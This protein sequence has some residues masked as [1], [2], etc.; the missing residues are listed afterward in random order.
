MRTMWS[1][2]VVLVFLMLM[3][4][5]EAQPLL[6]QWQK[7]FGGTAFE[8]GMDVQQT[9]DGGYVMA[10]FA[11]SANGDLTVNKGGR[12]FWVV[13]TDASRTIQWQISL[14][15][16]NDDAASMVKQTIDGGFIVCGTTSSADGDVTGYHGGGSD[17]WV[18]KLSST[19]TVLWKKTIGGT[20]DDIATSLDTEPT[21]TY[22]IAGLT[23]SNDGDVSGNHGNYD[24]FVVR[25][26]NNGN[27]I[28]QQCFGGTGSDADPKIKGT[29]DGGFM[30]VASTSSSD[31]DVSINHG[32]YDYWL[33]RVNNQNYITMN[34]TYGGLV[35]DQPY[36]VIQTMD[37]GY[38]I[39][40][41]ANSND[42]DV[43]GHHGNTG[44][45]DWWV[46]KLNANGSIQWQQSY[47]GSSLDVAHAILQTAD[48][49]YLVAGYVQSLDGNVTSLHG[50]Q[51]GDVDGAPDMWVIRT[52]GYGTLLWQNTFGG[53]GADY[54]NDLI[55][56]TSGIYI[57]CGVT[58]S[59]DG[60]VTGN[61][62]ADHDFWLLGLQDSCPLPAMPLRI[63]QTGGTTAVC[64]GEIR[65]Y[66]TPAKPGIS[67]QWSVPTGMVI[68]SGQGTNSIN[69]SFNQNFPQYDYIE[70][71]AVN[72]CGTSYPIRKLVARNNLNVPGTIYIDGGG[73]SVCPGES[74]TFSIDS[75]SQPGVTYFWEVP[76]G[77]TI[78]SGQNSTTI[79]VSFDV[80]FNADGFIKA[81]KVNACG[82]SPARSLKIFRNRTRPATPAYIYAADQKAC[83]QDTLTFSTSTVDTGIIW[84]WYSSNT[85]TIIGGQGTSSVTAVTNSNFTG[86]WVAVYT[87]NNCNISFS[88]SKNIILDKAPAIPS[89]INGP[90]SGIC[91]QQNVVYSVQKVD[92]LNYTWTVTPPAIISSGQ[93]S[94]SIT[95]NYPLYVYNGTITVT[96]SNRCGISSVRSLIVRSVPATP[97]IITGPVT[98]CSNS[99]GNVYSINPV[100]S[101]GTY[102]W[103]GPTGSEISVNGITLHQNT[104]STTSTVVSID[105][106][107]VDAYSQ[108]KVRGSNVCGYGGVRVLDLNP[109]NLRMEEGNNSISVYPNPFTDKIQVNGTFSGIYKIS[110]TDV[111]GKIVYSTFIDSNNG[112]TMEL[113]PGEIRSG[114]YLLLVEGDQGRNVIRINKQ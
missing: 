24:V 48:G 55:R 113:N 21:Q 54:A 70:V 97:G 58:A 84:H 47:G 41:S 12:D 87:E 44:I 106:G 107:T 4:A 56:N 16:S 33:V 95:I 20:G 83:A 82:M 93:G 111:Q 90:S 73:S 49:G 11:T 3:S 77:A 2:K 39:A 68:N 66:T 72:T 25:L 109:C 36:D 42:G 1:N 38:A 64:P 94:N 108:V 28:Y 5:V 78:L 43:T 14:G 13:K 50:A 15:G 18:V 102:T 101:A 9:N 103:I 30:F 26:D 27:I 74:R 80:S 23:S 51:P 105:F 63:T 71:R 31:G 92:D 91:W 40:G 104:F 75:A 114:I 52:D 8:Y 76:A 19:G 59:Q 69:V 98:V 17:Y 46:V 45:F 100:A 65:T 110:L 79:D 96:A 34:R 32:A 62:S 89:A 35:D 22:L 57:V 88:R 61:H 37:G 10:G 85:V 81:Y 53:T 6:P 112:N 7:A 99:T 29:F 86:G 67:Y 60:D